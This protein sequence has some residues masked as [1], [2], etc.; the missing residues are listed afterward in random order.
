[1][2]RDEIGTLAQ[3]FA[4]MRHSLDQAIKMLDA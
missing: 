2:A 1:M 4:R 3:S